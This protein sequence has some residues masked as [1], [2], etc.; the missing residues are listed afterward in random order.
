VRVTQVEI[1]MVVGFLGQG[2][3]GVHQRE[4]GREVAGAEPRVQGREEGTPVGEPGG[5]DLGE[6]QGRR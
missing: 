3:D 4:A 6:G 2:S 1:R 5:L